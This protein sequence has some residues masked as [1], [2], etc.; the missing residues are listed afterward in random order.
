VASIGITFSK[1]AGKSTGGGGFP[2]VEAARKAEAEHRHEVGKQT[3]MEMTPDQF[4]GYLR[5]YGQ[6]IASEYYDPKGRI[7]INP[8]TL[9]Q[10][11]AMYF[12]TK[13]NE[14]SSEWHVNKMRRFQRQFSDWFDIEARTVTREDV[15]WHRNKVA[16]EVSNDAANKDLALLKSIYRWGIDEG[17]VDRNPCQGV[18][19]LDWERKERYIP[20]DHDVLEVQKH[21]PMVW[22]W[23]YIEWGSII[24]RHYKGK[25]GKLRR[26]KLPMTQELYFTLRH[27]QAQRD[28]TNPYVFPS[29]KTKDQRVKFQPV[30]KKACKEAGVPY[31]SWQCLRHYAATKLLKMGHRLEMIQRVLGH[32][33]KIVT[34]RYLEPIEDQLAEA[35]YDYGRE[36]EEK[37]PSVDREIK[38]IRNSTLYKTRN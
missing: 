9:G 28:K 7:E 15:R 19:T 11:A 14:E 38:D 5:D 12:K 13:K 24:L 20:S 29:P 36:V 1:S 18:K 3:K 6:V 31:F 27:V 4:L 22:E 21:L 30:L 32:S 26:H 17:L 8:L 35:M 37:S 25:D 34:E 16:E 2:T 23:I 10:L 33:N